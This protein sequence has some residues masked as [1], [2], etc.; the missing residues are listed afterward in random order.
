MEAVTEPLTQGGFSME[1][2]QDQLDVRE[3]VHGFAAERRPPRRGGVGRARGDALAADPGGGE[4]RPLQL[5]GAG[6][7]LRR[8]VRPDAADRQRGAVLGRRRDRHVDHGHDARRRRDL[9]LRHRR[10]VR[11]VGP[12]VLR[13]RGR[14]EGRRVLRLRA[15]RRLRRV[16]PANPRQV[17]R[18]A[19]TSGSS[20]ARRPGPPTA[21]SPT[22]T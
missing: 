5:R 8:R 9:L 14:A 15:R 13:H 18:E 7:V 17:R 16:L 3:W 22:C 1:L 12:A 10:A 19:P 11:R 6:A 20:T 21:A 2:S 4:D